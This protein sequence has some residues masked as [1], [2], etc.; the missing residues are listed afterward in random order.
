[1]N[2]VV[3]MSSTQLADLLGFKTKSSINKAIKNMFCDKLLTGDIGLTTDTRGYVKDYHLKEVDADNFIH[4]HSRKSPLFRCVREKAVL[5][6]IEQLTGHHIIRQFK[7]LQY[8]VDG[9][10]KETN[11][12]YEVDE[13]QHYL[14]GNLSAACCKRQAEVV[15][16]LKCEFV[17]IR[18]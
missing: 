7:V 11:T 15:A 6:T 8:R 12:V 10:C 5:D 18:V 1:M 2:T 4:R 9:F 14:G 3:T 13:S 17:R 16:T